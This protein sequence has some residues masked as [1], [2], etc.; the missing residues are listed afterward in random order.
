MSDNELC[1]LGD[2]DEALRNRKLLRSTAQIL[3]REIGPSPTDW[4]RRMSNPHARVQTR[5]VFS[6][7]LDLIDRH[8]P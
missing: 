6:L 1:N 3:R 4:E 5:F 8:T 2:L 7:L